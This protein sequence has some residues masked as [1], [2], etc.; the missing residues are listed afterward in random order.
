MR[1]LLLTAAAVAAIAWTA[2]AGA[3]GQHGITKHDR[4]VIQFFKHHP[5]LAA[6]PAGGRVLSKLLPRLTAELD[7]A[8]AL[9]AAA[10]AWPVHHALWVC[11]NRYESRGNWAGVNPNGH[12]GGL[13]MS[14]GWL[15][16]ISG[17]ADQLSQLEQERAAEEGYRRSGYLESF[18]W[19]QWFNYDDAEGECLQYA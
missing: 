11:I 6:T 17:R 15:G 2:S 1:S 4:Q 18:L 14:Y 16:L 10:T 3:T 8:R 7:K 19:G 13:Q 9:Q 5:R 12:Y